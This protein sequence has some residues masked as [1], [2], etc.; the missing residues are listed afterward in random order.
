MKLAVLLLVC[1][2]APAF[3]QESNLKRDTSSTDRG[4]P[5]V[6][7]ADR[8]AAFPDLGNMT[9]REHADDNPLNV[10]V[11]ADRLEIRDARQA[12]PLVWD[13]SIW[14]GRDYNKLLLRTEGEI[15]KARVEA[16]NVEALWVRPFARWWD[17]AVGARHEFQPRQSRSWL[18]LGVTGLAPYRFQVEATAYVGETGRTALQLQTK[19][20]LLLTNRLILQPRVELNAYGR[21]DRSRGIG[22]GVSDLELGLRLRYEIRREI[23]PYFGVAW[24]NKFGSTADLARVQGV[25]SHEVQ[26]LA[27]LRVWY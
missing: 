10:M 9:M 11:L 19:Y 3:A 17:L 18:A 22:S 16:G 23:A 15:V 20:D 27:G 6:T 13:A 26:V 7:D 2:A 8:A 21:S 24:A 14:V 1:I 25:A 12:S 5:P 4:Y